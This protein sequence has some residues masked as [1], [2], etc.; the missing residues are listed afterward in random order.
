MT[1]DKK[2]ELILSDAMVAY[3][4]KDT[5]E[6]SDQIEI[7]ANFHYQEDNPYFTEK[8]LKQEYFDGDEQP[9]SYW[10]TTY[11]QDRRDE[12]YSFLKRLFNRKI[13]KDFVVS[14]GEE[15]DPVGLGIKTKRPKKYKFTVT[16][17]YLDVLGIYMNL[18]NHRIKEENKLNITDTPTRI[19]KVDDPIT[20]TVVTSLQKKP[21][22]PLPVRRIVVH[23]LEPE[24]YNKRTGLLTLS[25]TDKVA[26]SKHG[27]ARKK[28]GLKFEQ[29]H[30]MACI[31]KDVNTLKNGVKTS[32]ILGV[33]ASL[34]NKKHDKKIRNLLQEINEKIAEVGGPNNLVKVQNQ[35]VFVNSSYLL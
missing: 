4:L 23:A 25:P 15:E 6:G 21:S 5:Y 30:L 31:F 9:V 35:K 12:E 28:N 29:C 33:H 18:A 13:I 19:V 1:I 22:E 32:L 20:E 10:G 24:H 14:F 16:S 2:R 3:Q 11:I 7:Y 34:I 27:S 26:I 8:Y 17:T